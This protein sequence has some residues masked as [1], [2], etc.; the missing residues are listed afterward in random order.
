MERS[1]LLSLSLRSR[2]FVDLAHLLSLS[3]RSRQFVDHLSF[4]LILALDDPS[5]ESK[6][7]NL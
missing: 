4:F 2:Q 3:L 7:K 1:L 5:A 6:V